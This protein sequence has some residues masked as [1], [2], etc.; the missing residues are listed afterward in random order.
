MPSLSARQIGTAAL[1][2]L[3][4][5]SAEQPISA[6]MAQSALE[7]LNTMLDSWSTE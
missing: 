7:A 4:V 1:L 5:A 3:G 6:F 2:M